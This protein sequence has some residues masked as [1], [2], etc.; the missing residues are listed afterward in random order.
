M[1]MARKMDG[2]LLVVGALNTVLKKKEP[3]RSQLEPMLKQHILPAFASP[4]GHVRAPM[5]PS[6]CPC[7]RFPDGDCLH[8]Q[9]AESAVFHLQCQ[10]WAC[11]LMRPAYRSILQGPQHA[12]FCTAQ[13]CGA[14]RSEPSGDGVCCS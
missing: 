7:V 12:A 9:P 5:L 3:Y 13:P 2:A 14:Q 6:T 10:T 4:W 8:M 1:A 11:K